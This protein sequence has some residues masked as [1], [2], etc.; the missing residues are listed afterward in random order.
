MTHSL[1]GVLPV[2]HT[3]FHASG[4]IDYETLRAEIDYVYAAGADGIV[5]AMVSEVL[6]LSERERREVAEFMARENAGR[7][8]VTIS[9]G[10]E[11]TPQAVAY[12]R[13][14]EE[15]GATALMAI[16]PLSA[17]LDETQ[18]RAYY[19]AIVEAT[20]LPVVVQD[21]SGYVG[22]PLAAQ[23]QAALWREWGERV[24][25]KPE[26]VPVGPVISAINE[27]TGGGAGIFDGSGGTFLVD[28]YRRGLAGTMPGSDLID[29]LVALW[30]ALQNGDEER[31]DTIA[32]LVTA[33]LAHATSLDA[34]VALEKHILVRRGIFRNT[35]T[36]APAGY[37]LDEVTRAEVD[38]LFDR[39]QTV[40][41]GTV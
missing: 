38:R 9:V 39:L 5:L 20:A 24:L 29:S 21:A 33:L 1:H 4:E 15:S 23:F 16:P 12:A 41:R 11:S 2:L 3:P 26:S 40:T 31:I 13:H 35:L 36:R 34:Y 37:A 6:R 30:R 7:G 25:F 19:A 8:S 22:Q 18:L 32:P 17:A 27:L 14:A 10:A 28:S